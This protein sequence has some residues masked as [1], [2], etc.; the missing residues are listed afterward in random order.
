MSVIDFGQNLVGF[1]RMKGVHGNAGH[2]ITFSHA[3]IMERDELGRRP[4]RGA[5][6][7]DVYTLKGGSQGESWEPR[8]TFHGFRYVEVS[9]WASDSGDL[10][11]CIEAVVVHTDMKRIGHFSCSDSLLN[12]L[13]ENIVW[14]MRGNFV[15]IPTDCPQRD[16]RLGWTGDLALYAPT[17]SLIYDCTSMLDGWLHNVHAEQRKHGGVPPLVVPNV[18]GGDTI[19]GQVKPASIWGDVVVLAPWALYEATGD[20]CILE[21][22]YQGMIDWLATIPKNINGNSHLW[23][24][25]HPQLGV[26][27]CRLATLSPEVANRRQ[28]WLD[29]TAPPD[30]PNLARTDAVLVSNAYLVRSL[31]I[32]S[33]VAKILNREDDATK[34]ETEYIAALDEFTSEYLTPSGRLMSDTQTGYALAVTFDLLST[35]RQKARAFE[36]L[37]FIVRRS[38]FKISTGFAGTPFICEAL[39]QA[40]SP[41][42]AYAMITNTECPSWLYPVTMGAT[43]MWERWDSMLPD[44]SINPG[45][46]TSF[47]HFAFGAVAKFMYERLAGLQCA[48]PGWSR[49]RIAPVV[50]GNLTH[51]QASLETPYGLLS[52]RWRLQGSEHQ[53]LTIEAVIPPNSSAEIIF[54]EGTDVEPVQLCSGT[55]SFSVAFLQPNAWPVQPLREY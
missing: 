54:P 23:E 47:N 9:G 48:A 29:L 42:I 16:E 44:G 27:S 40:G 12:R 14:S 17:G 19:F 11:D 18:L 24:D 33:D 49:A 13:H 46:M 37:A 43:T 15:S 22:H 30:R 6:N 25:S 55:H 21:G 1:T 53:T 20:T 39:V 2:Q 8:F 36:R 41:Q 28:D 3:E 31:R 52:T 50:G 4:L 51:A 38:G 34:Y 7:T 35:T 5:D 45:D 26:S 10:L 32:V